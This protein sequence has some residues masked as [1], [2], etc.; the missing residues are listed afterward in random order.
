MLNCL[1]RESKSAM[2]NAP[3]Q[4]PA[5]HQPIGIFDSGIGGLTVAK[6]VMSALP[7]ESIV[8][9]GDTAH[10]P[11]G[12]KSAAAIR[13]YSLKICDF[14]LQ[15][16]CKLIL[17]A[18]NS[19]S[20]A[21]FD[22]VK[23]HVGD[24]ALVLDVIEPVVNHVREKYTEKSLGLIGTRQ[25]VNSNV[26]KEKIEAPGCTS[27]LKALATPLLVP[28]IESGYY[29]NSIIDEVIF[30]YLTDPT[31][32][33]IDALILGCTHYPLIK[34]K[35]V[36]YLHKKQKQFV[37]VIDASTLVAAMVAETLAANRLLH[38]GAKQPNQFF[39]SDYT[40][41]FRQT[42]QLFFPETVQLQSYTL[43]E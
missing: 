2:I 40:E 42:T 17:I 24:R 27:T 22:V 34:Q 5:A 33:D 11:Y 21:A 18:C 20:S 35:I 1:K 38:T 43:W 3:K 6:A 14:L 30:D 37:D 25:T 36:E 7:N 29:K 41:S 9:F 19:A 8:Y 26:Y 13:G 16:G 23:I 28:M 15:H 32:A 31:L 10:L 12:D 4:T 39:L